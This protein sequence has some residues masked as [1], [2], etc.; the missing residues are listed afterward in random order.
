MAARRA[1]VTAAAA[2]TLQTV[3]ISEPPV[4]VR[5]LCAHY[6]FNLV[7][8][9]G[10]RTGTH[11]AQWQ[12]T[13]RE[14]RFNAD[15]PQVRRRFSIAHEIGHVVLGHT[16]TTFSSSADAEHDD[17]SEDPD[18]TLEAEADQFARELLMPPAWIR[19]D[20]ERGLRWDDLAGRYVVSR[21][22]AAV[23]VDRYRLI[24]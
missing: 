19:D 23:A 5:A 17:F 14:I 9:H 13:L 1:Y 15:E 3:G 8:V 20:W 21:D 2:R 10:W 18:R 6:A 22:A 11:S 4:S 24:K 7:P 12:P 16:V